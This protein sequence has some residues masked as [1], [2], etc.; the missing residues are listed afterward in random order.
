MLHGAKR[1]KKGTTPK[2]AEV[3]L[4]A[5]GSKAIVLRFRSTVADVSAAFRK[6][7]VIGEPSG[8]EAVKYLHDVRADR[9][10]RFFTGTLSKIA[11][12]KKLALVSVAQ[13]FG[14]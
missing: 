2:V 14:D 12:E 11:D 8:P 3:G 5:E 13:A 6:I 10:A 9:C 1:E 4:L 7:V